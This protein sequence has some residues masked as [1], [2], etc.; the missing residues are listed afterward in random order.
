M[1]DFTSI[2]H[3]TARPGTR[4]RS[5][6]S[7]LA[8]NGTCCWLPPFRCGARRG[9]SVGR[10]SDC[11]DRSMP[12][13]QVEGRP[14]HRHSVPR[15]PHAC[16]TSHVSHTGSVASCMALRR[17]CPPGSGTGE[18]AAGWRHAWQERT[19]NDSAVSTGPT[20]GSVSQGQRWYL[21]WTCARSLWQEALQRTKREGGVPSMST[22]TLGYLQRFTLNFSPYI[23]FLR[24]I[25]NISSS[26]FLPPATVSPKFFY[27]YP[28]ST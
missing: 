25:V 4:D 13:Q 17:H 27:L 23:T 12:K 26:T 2:V 6:S 11:L 21:K 15:T 19:A 10:R 28:T 16:F 14:T 8:C 22:V 20:R 7:G 18:K 5:W 1:C 9:A 24:H 3:G